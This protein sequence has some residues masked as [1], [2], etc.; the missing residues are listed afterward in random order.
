[1]EETGKD[2]KGN[3]LKKN[4]RL[5]TFDLTLEPAEGSPQK[6]YSNCYC[7]GPAYPPCCGD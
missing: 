1:M 5:Q 6:K 3:G 2:K 7:Y 4:K